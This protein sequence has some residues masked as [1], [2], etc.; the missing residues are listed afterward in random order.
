MAVAKKKKVAKKV[1]SARQQIAIGEAAHAG[2]QRS[3]RNDWV[4]AAY[5][6]MTKRPLWAHRLYKSH[7]VKWRA[8]YRAKRIMERVS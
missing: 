7:G 3:L 8:L 2:R 6:A 5:Y 1:D 4:D